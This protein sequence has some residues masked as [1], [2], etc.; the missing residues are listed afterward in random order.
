MRLKQNVGFEPPTLVLTP[1]TLRK[2]GDSGCSQRPVGLA[3]WSS[4]RGLTPR[5][6]EKA[7]DDDHTL[8]WR[9]FLPALS[10]CSATFTFFTEVG[11]TRQTNSDQHG[12]ITDLSAPLVACNLRVGGP[13]A[14]RQACPHLFGDPSQTASLVSQCLA[15]EPRQS[16]HPESQSHTA[17]NSLKQRGGFWPASIGREVSPLREDALCLSFANGSE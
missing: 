1:H 12:D 5:R 15:L 11:R 3:C 6:A 9:R 13:E 14:A 7:M 4:A 8:R 10:L 17:H 2:Y 16:A